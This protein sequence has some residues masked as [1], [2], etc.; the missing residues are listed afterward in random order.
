MGLIK[1]IT[2]NS[3][4]EVNDAYFRIDS[5]HSDQVSCDITITAYISREAY[6]GGKAFLSAERHDFKPE[7]DD[8]A[9]NIFRQAYAYLKSVDDYRDAEDVLEDGQ[10]PLD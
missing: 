2:L 7:T 3:G 4:L 8:D 10:T 5:L 1:S 9:P 6:L